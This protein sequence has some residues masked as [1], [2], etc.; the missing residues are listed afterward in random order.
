MKRIFLSTYYS[1]NGIW[2]IIDT[3]SVKLWKRCG[4]TDGILHTANCLNNQVRWS[5]G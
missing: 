4:S 5:N 1:T 2:T 3:G